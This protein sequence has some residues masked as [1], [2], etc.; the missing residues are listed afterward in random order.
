MNRLQELRD[1]HARL[2]AE[3]EPIRSRQDPENPWT[4]EERETLARIGERAAEIEADIALL[5]PLERSRAWSEGTRDQGDPNPSNNNGNG[6]GNGGG[7]RSADD[8]T[9]PTPTAQRPDDDEYMRQAR[10]TVNRGGGDWLQAQNDYARSG[11][12]GAV[13]FWGRL[14]L[15]DRSDEGPDDPDR[16]RAWLSESAVAGG[17]LVPP[18]PLVQMLI[19]EQRNMVFVEELSEIAT[20]SG[21]R[22]HTIPKLTARP[23]D[24]EWTTETPPTG[25]V[26]S[27]M[28]FGRL[29]FEPHPMRGLI[30]EFS[31]DELEKDE[32]DIEATW[33][34]NLQYLVGIKKER[35]YMLGNGVNQPLGLFFPHDDG[36]PTSRDV[37][38]GG[39]TEITYQGLVDALFALKEQYQMRSTWVLGR[40]AMAQVFG[41]QDNEGRPIWQSVAV[42]PGGDFRG[43]ILNRPYRMSEY[44]PNANKA[45]FVAN[46]YV[47]IIGDFMAGYRV[48]RTTYMRMIRDPYTKSDNNIIRITTRYYGDGKPKLG[49][50]FARIKIGT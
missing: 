3:A 18:M 43:M 50:A 28:T 2:M 32:V 13:R 30:A 47:A 14:G 7:N 33:R 20:I 19:E 45:A 39:S 15:Q 31:V 35:A 12:S 24:P 36:I 29:R 8:P 41:L 46:D 9:D 49:E 42:G 38:S 16:H 34:S 37:K 4:P 23:S 11:W 10:E 44:V 48:L 27:Q 25:D 6:N 5:E 22:G 17:Y 21:L 40:K 1:E 26:D